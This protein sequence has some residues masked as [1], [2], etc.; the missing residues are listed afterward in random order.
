MYIKGHEDVTKNKQC[1]KY[2]QKRHQLQ[3][4]TQASL[5]SDEAQSEYGHAVVCPQN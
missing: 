2:I 1:C 3:N 4:E 5:P